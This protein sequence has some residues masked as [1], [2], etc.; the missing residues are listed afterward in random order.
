MRFTKR[1]II[2]TTYVAVAAA[3]YGLWVSGAALPGLHSTRATG[4]LALA[5]GFAASATAVVPTF[6]QLLRG[7]KLYLAITALVGVVA[8]V[9]GVL[10][11]AAASDGALAVM[12]LA[13]VGLWAIATVHHSLLAAPDTP[14]ATRHLTWFSPR[15]PHPTGVH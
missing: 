6:A 5:L 8:V 4:S 9:G 11:L 15:G 1:D 10:A 14:R 12:M 7:N 13:M 3:V 2:A